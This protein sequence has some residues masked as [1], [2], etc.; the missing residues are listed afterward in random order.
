MIK[1][2]PM[3]MDD[4]SLAQGAEGL[5][6]QLNAMAENLATFQ[7]TVGLLP[8]GRLMYALAQDPNGPTHAIYPIGGYAKPL[9]PDGTSGPHRLRRVA[10][11]AARLW[12]RMTPFLLQNVQATTN[13]CT[14]GHA[15][16]LGFMSYRGLDV[17]WNG[18]GWHVTAGVY[19]FSLRLPNMTPLD[20]IIV[21]EGELPGTAGLIYVD[22]GVQLL[23][24]SGVRIT[25][26]VVRLHQGRGSMVVRKTSDFKIDPNHTVDSFYVI[27]PARVISP[28]AYV[29]PPK[30]RHSAP[31]VVTMGNGCHPTDYSTSIPYSSLLPGPFPHDA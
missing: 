15:T 29:L 20:D 7:P 23:P 18:R 21:P 25:S 16:S 12:Q 1:M 24:K 6:R 3:P 14:Q 27:A 22:F 5:E 26:A 17:C 30:D 28:L 19:H 4:D 13:T 9:R 10:L 8:D 31:A 11:N 2:T